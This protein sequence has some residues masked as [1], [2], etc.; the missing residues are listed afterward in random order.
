MYL[1]VFLW[2]LNEKQLKKSVVHSR[3]ALHPSSH[4]SV[5]HKGN[6]DKEERINL[7][8]NKEMLSDKYCWTKLL[9]F[10]LATGTVIVSSPFQLA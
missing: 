8:L 4:A 6:I 2:T 3:Q 5:G 7:A 10:H 1:Q 9:K